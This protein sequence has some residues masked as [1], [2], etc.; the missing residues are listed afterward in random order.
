M[1]ALIFNQYV[2]H[3]SLSKR[4][5][6]KNPIPYNLAFQLSITVCRFKIAYILTHILYVI[7]ILFRIIISI[8]VKMLFPGF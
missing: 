5:V 6:D 2:F 3:A 1:Y 4:K 8:I 7:N